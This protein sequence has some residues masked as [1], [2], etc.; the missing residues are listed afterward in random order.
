MKKY[1]KIIFS[2]F[3]AYTANATTLEQTFNVEIGVFDAAKA[4]VSYTLNDADYLFSSQIKTSGMFDN[5]YSFKAEYLTSGELKENSF[6]TQNYQQKTQSSAH[7]RKK[8]L[9]FDKNGILT[10][11]ISSKDNEQKKVDITLPDIKIDAFDIQ[12]V[13]I[14]LIKNFKDTHSCDLNKTVFNGKKIYHITV[15][16]SGRVL[17]K[18]KKVPLSGESFACVAFIHQE[19]VEEGDLLWK[20][21][22]ER[23][24]KFYL[25]LDKATNL[26][27]LAKM[28]I[29][30]TPLGK[31]E[32]YI[33][34][35]E[36]KE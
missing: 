11:R 30:S 29:A 26:P 2:V 13:L 8:H 12:T 5:F 20:V 31:L 7:L 14:M 1:F 22:S 28:E 35:L 10:Q 18:D 3:I 32:A 4:Q 25:M 15:K 19:K 33:T 23:N 36:I 17:F 6:L 24:I 9:L 16:D 34:D 27:F 21:S